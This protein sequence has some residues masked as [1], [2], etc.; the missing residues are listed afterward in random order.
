M[1]DIDKY[2]EKYVDDYAYD[3]RTTTT[4]NFRNRKLWICRHFEREDHH[5][6]YVA[7]KFRVGITNHIWWSRSFSNVWSGLSYKANKINE[8]ER[9]QTKYFDKKSGKLVP[10]E[11]V[12]VIVLEW[13]AMQ[14][15]L[16][17][18]LNE[19]KSKVSIKSNSSR[20][21]N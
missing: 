8:A 1:S 5:D 18:K 10:Y 20:K 13:S 7:V 11:E 9:M 19:A 21:E 15:V 12:E 4:G 2:T 6:G 3:F 14:L 17:D 16:E